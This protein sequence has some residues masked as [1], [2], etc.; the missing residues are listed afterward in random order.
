[1]E[2]EGNLR[3]HS[4][5]AALLSILYI[6]YSLE[7]GI[8]LML[9]PWQR[10]WDNNYFLSQLP[11]LRQI[12]GNPFFKGAVLGL[13][14]VNLIIGLHEIVHFRKRSATFFFR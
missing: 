14:I 9:I 4:I 7:V 2:D 12:V 10:I 11:W 5:W 3:S 8:F 6:V 13:G 1:M